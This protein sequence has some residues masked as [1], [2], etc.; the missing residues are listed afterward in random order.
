MT[1]DEE[2]LLLLK[3]LF[4]HYTAFIAFSEATEEQAKMH[5]NTLGIAHRIEV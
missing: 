2:I 1:C 4:E 5:P 3:L